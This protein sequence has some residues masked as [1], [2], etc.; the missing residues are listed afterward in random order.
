MGAGMVNYFT[1]T[2]ILFTFHMFVC[3]GL[4]QTNF[5]KVHDSAIVQ[6]VLPPLEFVLK[7]YSFAI[8]HSS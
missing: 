1:S 2:I 5:L 3:C 7:Y 6:E 8:I 4:K